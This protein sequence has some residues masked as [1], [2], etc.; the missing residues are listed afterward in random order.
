MPA[1]MCVIRYHQH[2][3]TLTFRVEGR[4]SMAQSVPLRRKAEELITQDVTTIR[5]DLRQCTYMDSTFVGTLLTLKKTLDKRQG[6]FALIMPST[7]C[8]K[9]LNQM[10]L[11]D[12]LNTGE[13]DMDSQT[14][15]IELNCEPPDPAAL[16]KNMIDAHTHEEFT[17]LPGPVGEQFKQVVRVINKESPAEGGDK[18][19]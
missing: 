6:T 11:T 15:W 3:H 2:E 18:G 10:G 14:P 1:P 16:K 9:I 7:A 12:I 17:N 4:G 19:S 8:S 5:L 13:D